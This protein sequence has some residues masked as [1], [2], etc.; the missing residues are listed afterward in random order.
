[1]GNVAE[2]KWKQFRG[3]MKK[4]WGKL[5]DD[6]FDV[7]DGNRDKLVG[8][9]QERYGKERTVAEKEVATFFDSRTR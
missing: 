8:R 9:I 5:T 1:M 7:A 3:E 2:G 6:D 4:Q